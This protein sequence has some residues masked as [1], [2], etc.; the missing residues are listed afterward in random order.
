MDRYTEMRRYAHR[1][2]E[3][4]FELLKCEMLPTLREIQKRLLQVEGILPEHSSDTVGFVRFN[5]IKIISSINEFPQWLYSPDERELTD[6]DLRTL[7]HEIILS[8]KALYYETYLIK[9]QCIDIIPE[10]TMQD[11]HQMVEMGAD[12]VVVLEGLMGLSRPEML[13]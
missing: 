8:V 1:P 2:A 9:C 5:A 10:E 7:R 12:L 6:G 13:A 4:K 11:I 3:E